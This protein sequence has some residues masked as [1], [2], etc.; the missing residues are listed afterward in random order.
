MIDHRLSELRVYQRLSTDHSGSAG[1]SRF[2][3]PATILGLPST[4]KSPTILTSRGR[5]EMRENVE[6]QSFAMGAEASGAGSAGLLDHLVGES[7]KRRRHVEA[8][9]F[10]SLEIDD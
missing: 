1:Y 8:E 4:A 2:T 5:S 7:K 9:C 6:R 10:G 3:I